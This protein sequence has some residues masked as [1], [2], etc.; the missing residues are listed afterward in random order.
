MS[1]T[2][3]Q[4][5]A[6]QAL[7]D[8]NETLESRVLERTQQV[9]DL[10]SKLTMAE[11][12]ERRRVSQV[13]HDDLQQLLYGLQMRLRMIAGEAQGTGQWEQKKLLADTQAWVVKAIETTRQLTVD[14]SPPILKKEGLADALGWLKRQM[15]QLHALEME[16]HTLQPPDTLDEDLRVLLFQVVRELLFNV[17]KHSHADHARVEL[18]QTDGQI[19]IRVSDSGDGFDLAVMEAEQDDH[20]GFGLVSIRE[21][22]SLLG[23]RMEIDAVPGSGTSILLM[24]P[25]KREVEKPTSQASTQ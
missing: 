5:L 21:R 13:L 18:D 2:N 15:Q 9:R 24:M 3:E 25:V 10:A 20:P 17:K 4:K 11:Q 12:E 16:V 23:G 8:I 1:D 6:E 22:L 7:K 14:L 19:I